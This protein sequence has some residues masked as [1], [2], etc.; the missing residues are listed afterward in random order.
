MHQDCHLVTA[1]ASPAHQNFVTAINELK[2]CKTLQPV[3][4]PPFAVVVPKTGVPNPSILLVHVQN[5]WR[6]RVWER[7][8]PALAGLSQASLALLKL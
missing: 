4:G 6:A 5:Q 8:H 1:I 7:L 3:E 2:L